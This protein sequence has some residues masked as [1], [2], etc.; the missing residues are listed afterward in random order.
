MYTDYDSQEHNDQDFV[1]NAFQNVR[2]DDPARATILSRVT[3]SLLNGLVPDGQPG[4]T[5]G[6]I[7]DLTGFKEG[8]I[9]DRLGEIIDDGELGCLPG[10]GRRP[11]YYVLFENPEETEIKACEIVL[12]RVQQ[13]KHKLIQKINQMSIQLADCEATERCLLQMSNSKDQEEIDNEF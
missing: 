7:C 3:E 1:H 4:L 6:D 13:R 5:I 8:F 10:A 11:S 2:V 12:L 9:R